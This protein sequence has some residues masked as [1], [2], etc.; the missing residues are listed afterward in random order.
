MSKLLHTLVLL[1]AIVL[2]VVGSR[3]QHAI[4]QERQG[5]YMVNDR[6]ALLDLSEICPSPTFVVT[7]TTTEGLGTGDIQVTLRWASTDDLDLEVIDPSGQT[8][9]YYNPIIASG[10]QL[11]VDANAACNGTTTQ[12]IENIFWPV[13]EAPSGNYTIRV[14]L[15]TRCDGSS[16]PIPFEIRL[17]TRGNIETLTGS[18]DDGSSAASFPFSLD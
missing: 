11:D 14:N 13:S 1:S 7:E 9:A 15:F 10:G 16:G 17:L 12:P 2:P 18:V 5:C 4:A 3:D 8:V 6:G